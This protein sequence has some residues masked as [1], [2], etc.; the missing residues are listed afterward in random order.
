M[1]T[2]ALIAL[3]VVFVCCAVVLWLTRPRRGPM[4]PGSY[5]WMWERC[6]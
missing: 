1:R 2:A 5:D 6:A 3:L 4:Q